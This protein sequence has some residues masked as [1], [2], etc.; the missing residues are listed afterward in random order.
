MRR[1]KVRRSKPPLSPNRLEANLR[2]M[3]RCK[4]TRGDGTG[5]QT[6]SQ[7]RSFDDYYVSGQRAGQWATR[8][9]VGSAQVSG[10]PAGMSPE[11]RCS[12]AKDGGLCGGV[13]LKVFQIDE[14]QCGDVRRFEHDQ[15]CNA[16]FQG[17]APSEHAQAPAITRFE[18]RKVKLGYWRDEVV[19]ACSREFEKV[20]GDFGANQVQPQVI[21]AGSAASIA[22]ETRHGVGR[23]RQQ[24]GAENIAGGSHALPLG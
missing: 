6:C 16:G 23:A 3:H 17:F 1:S 5:S 18:P 15:G 13:V 2:W 20:L 9:S 11:V 19:P 10:Q 22:K 8:R 12:R 4:R 21:R 24:W 7:V 14:L